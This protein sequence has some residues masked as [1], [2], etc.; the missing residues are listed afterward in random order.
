MTDQPVRWGVLGCASIAL[1]RVIPAMAG[2]DMARLVAIA[3]RTLS[4]RP[5]R[6]LG[7]WGSRRR[8]GPMRRC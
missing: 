6:P 5:N 3:S 4:P 1:D 2:A 8:T 7:A